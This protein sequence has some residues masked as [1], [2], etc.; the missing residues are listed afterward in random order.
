MSEQRILLA[1]A[2]TAPAIITETL[3]ALTQTQQ[4]PFFPTQIHI[5]TTAGV[6]QRLDI[7][8]SEQS[9]LKTLCIDYAIPLPQFTLDHIHLITDQQGRV[10]RDLT[11]EAD[12]S[13]AAD[14]ITQLVRT[15]TA[16]PTTHLHVSL[17]GG[18]KTMGY[19]LGY[20]L[21]LYGRQ[22]DSLSH[23]MVDESL[24]NGD[25][26][27]PKPHEDIKV[28]L[29]NV[30][31]VRLRDGLAYAEELTQGKHTF[32]QAI[33]LVQRQ[34]SPIQVYFSHQQLRLGL[35]L[36][37]ILKPTELAVYLWFLMRHQQTLP[38]LVFS[39]AMLSLEYAKELIK[40]YQ[41][42]HGQR[43][44]SKMEKALHH[45]LTLDYLL[46]H[47]SRCN[48]GLKQTL[49]KAAEPYLVQTTVIGNATHYSLSPML[50]IE[51]IHL[52]LSKST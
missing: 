10:L 11:T 8:L 19:Y 14:F 43:G 30:P 51:H 33:Q 37:T 45:G 5:I 32:N 12:N 50:P 38:A 2:G 26:F 35:Q 25:F 42:L 23:V 15:F 34:F 29:A 6:R 39:K 3:Y 24:L 52:A 28:M 49:K 20:A 22:Q 18:R 9:P 47:I 36:I 31:F 7:L 27:Y 44:I 21:S 48:S 40:I 1:V 46:P 4:P 41:Q 13:A 17:A 16:D